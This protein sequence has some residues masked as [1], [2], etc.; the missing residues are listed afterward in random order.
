M[1]FDI[2]TDAIETVT[3]PTGGMIEAGQSTLAAAGAA[4]AGRAI[5]APA[6]AMAAAGPQSKPQPEIVSAIV[7]GGLRTS[8]STI[9]R[10][11]DKRFRV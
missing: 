7:S 2:R 6:A 10:Y 1:T 3:T 8:D 4:A 11:Q 9:H 5:A